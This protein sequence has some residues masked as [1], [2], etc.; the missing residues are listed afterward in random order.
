M[1]VIIYS[2]PTCPYC[3]QVKNYFESKNIDY[4]DIDVSSD[5]KSAQEM[6]DL[7]GQMGVPVIKIDDK[8]IIGFDKNKIDELLIK[9]NE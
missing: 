6:V 8:I 4:T 2:T 9:S 5:Q 1:K 3:L 7:S